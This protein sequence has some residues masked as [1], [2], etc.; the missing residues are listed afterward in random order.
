MN[1]IYNLTKEK[2][3]EFNKQLEDKKSEYDKLNS[4][5]EKDLWLIDLKQLKK[6]FKKTTKT[7][8]LKN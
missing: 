8:K 7:K 5:E 6:F 1:A 4:F 2:I 3:D